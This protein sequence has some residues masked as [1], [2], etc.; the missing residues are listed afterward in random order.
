MY[1]LFMLYIY[2]KEIR[3][4]VEEIDQSDNNILNIKKL[5]YKDMNKRIKV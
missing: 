2:R 3:E 5:N 4:N 1:F